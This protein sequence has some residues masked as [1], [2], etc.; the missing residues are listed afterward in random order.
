MVQSSH[1]TTTLEYGYQGNALRSVLSGLAH[2]QHDDRP[3]FTLTPRKPM[4]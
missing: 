2:Q 3:S 1:A 4:L